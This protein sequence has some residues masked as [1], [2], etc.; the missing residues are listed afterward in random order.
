M[1]YKITKK[2][3]GEF[4]AEIKLSASEWNDALN[5]AYEKNKGKYSI[6]GFRKG[7]APRNVIEKN[8]GKG[9]FFNE[10]LDEVYYKAY[11]QVLREH[12]EIKPIDSPKLNINKMDDEG[13]EFVLSI[14]CVAEFKL[15]N[16]KGNTFVKQAVNVTEQQIN[17]EIDKAL[18]RSSRLVETNKP[19]KMQD[20]VT[21]DFEGFIDGKAFDGGKATNYQ[22]KL[23]SHSFIDTFEDQLVGLN[24][25]DKKDVNVTFP[26][27]Y[28]E[29]SLANKPAT[30][31]VEIK[32]VR[33][34]IMPKLDEEFVKNSTEFE[35]VEQ[36]K[37]S[38]KDKL[39]KQA[40]Q[41]AEMEVENDMI[42]KLVD[43]TEL[44]VP[45]VMVNQE[46][47]RQLNGM[48]NQFRYQGLTLDDYCK[49]IGKT[50]DE[51]KAEIKQHA[52]RNVKARLVLEKLIEVEK[53]DITQKD[54]DNKI[55]EM[56]KNANQKVED[57]KKQ[58]NNDTINRIANELL[59]KNIVDMLVKNNT[60]E[61]SADKST[62]SKTKSATATKST[63][64]KSSTGT[65]TSASKTTT[66]TTKKSDK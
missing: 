9:A 6:P 50:M 62:T 17:E 51:L 5:T 55:E 45:E 19:A 22:L 18:M 48:A 33:E 61:Q 59:M 13:L 20:I 41:N 60:I 2:E 15:A 10:G 4:D 38:V 31:K 29:K 44:K 12:T 49:Y 28:Q 3:T 54:I 39:T 40:E 24:V 37:A 42:D 56:A 25:G 21:L 11:T 36:Y 66:K 43:D 63:T 1:E 30:F 35:T 32:A 64:S 46:V 57:F 8:Y 58:V 23:G 26:A 27:D 14:P 52:T 53:L 7:H 65:K 47:E 34:R 16:Y